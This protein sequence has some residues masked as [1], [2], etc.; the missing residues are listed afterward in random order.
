MQMN[1]HSYHRLIL[2]L[3]LAAVSL[4]VIAVVAEGQT[5]AANQAVVPSEEASQ[6]PPET[7]NPLPDKQP[8]AEEMPPASGAAVTPLKDFK[9]TEKI[10]A[11]SAVSFPIDI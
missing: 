11:D 3:L 7:D 6:A 1:E 10:D 5:S 9:P 4:P 2:L 8:D